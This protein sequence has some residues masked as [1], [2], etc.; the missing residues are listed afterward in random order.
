MT[1]ALGFPRT[2]LDTRTRVFI[3]YSRTDFK[4]AEGLVIDLEARNFKAY[5]DKQDI[6]AGEPWKKELG[7]LIELADAVLF[8]VSPDSVSSPMCD[9]EVN[10]AERLGKRLFPVLVRDVADNRVPGRLNS[11]NYALLRDTDDRAAAL[12]MLAEALRTDAEWIREHTRITE[13]AGRWDRHQR[14]LE[15]LLRGEDIRKAEEW[16]LRRPRSVP[17]LTPVI[18]DFVQPAAPRRRPDTYGAAPAPARNNPQPDHY[19]GRDLGNCDRFIIGLVLFQVGT[20][21]AD[22][23]IPVPFRP[24]AAAD[25]QWRRYCGHAACAGSVA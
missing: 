22:I 3:S 23:A 17:E 20:A 2:N 15:Q 13:L 7:V 12:A 9:W 19:L 16:A 6:M 4:A 8:L 1:D 18:L 10:E 14:L 24:R 5:L 25:E 11:L 21:G